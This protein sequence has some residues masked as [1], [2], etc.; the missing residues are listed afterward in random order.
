MTT[1]DIQ[2]QGDILSVPAGT[3]IFGSVSPA[4]IIHA[5]R[6]SVAHDKVASNI[7]FDERGIKVQQST[8]GKL[9]HLGVYDISVP[10]LM[11]NGPVLSMKV[12]IRPSVGK[13]RPDVA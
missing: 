7:K 10:L 9:K 11:E 5:I 4:E 3:P 12:D 6:E 8:D 13:E 2:V 1:K